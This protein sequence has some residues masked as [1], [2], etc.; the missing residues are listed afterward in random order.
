MGN[1]QN[2]YQAYTDGSIYSENPLNLVVALYEGALEATQQAAHALSARDIPARTKAIN[3]A[4]AILTELLVSLDHEKGGEISKNL[5]KLY[6]YMQVQ[7][8]AAHARQKPEPIT[9]VSKLLA[10]LLEGW[11]GA[12]VAQTSVPERAAVSFE[13]PLVKQHA[14]PAA[15]ASAAVYGGYMED[16][17]A[18]AG[19]AY[20]F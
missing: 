2:P 19:T 17:S 15:Y 6:N 4:I 13:V 5:A 16:A 9:E 3:K 10:T 14:A 7:L 20:S 1:D 18:L 11:R 12:V 8:C